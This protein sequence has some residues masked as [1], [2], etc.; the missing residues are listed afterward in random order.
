MV[1]PLAP[2]FSSGISQLAMLTL[3]RI[4]YPMGP[5]QCINL[6]V[7]LP[8]KKWVTSHP[9]VVWTYPSPHENPH[10][11]WPKRTICQQFNTYY[12]TTLMN[13][14][15]FLMLNIPQF[16]TL[17][18]HIPIQSKSWNII[19][20]Y[21]LQITGLVFSVVPSDS[22]DVLD[23]KNLFSKPKEQHSEAGALPLWGWFVDRPIQSGTWILWIF[24]GGVC[25]LSPS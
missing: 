10:S 19:K 12:V 5:S 18:D 22:K 14:P 20:L 25:C 24:W 11:W 21:I 17:Q 2:P 3:E 23:F 9:F 8:V 7:Y 16:L 1:F 15:P 4:R 6:W 13:K